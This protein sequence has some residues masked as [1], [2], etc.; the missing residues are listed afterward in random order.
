M[1]RY[2]GDGFNWYPSLESGTLIMRPFFRYNPAD[3]SVKYSEQPVELKIYPNPATT[4]L[5]IEASSRDEIV[6][7]ILAL[8]GRLLYE[9]KNDPH[10]QIDISGYPVGMYILEITQSDQLWRKKWMKY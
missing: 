8:D 5:N 3:M 6:V 10:T 1:P 4:V 7:R 9:Q 2:Y